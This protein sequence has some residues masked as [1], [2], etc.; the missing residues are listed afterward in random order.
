M[1][2]VPLGLQ[3]YERPSGFQPPTKLLNFYLEEDKSGA[4]PDQVMRLQRPGL[5]PFTTLT[6]NV[7]ALFYREG[8]NDGLPVAVAG[9]TLY[10]LD[11]GSNVIMG[12]VENDAARAHI[13]ANFEKIAV[14]SG[15]I[16]YT[17]DGSTLT[18]VDLP[19]DEA[20]IGLE[21]INGYFI[22]IL[23]DGTF[24]WLV[25][26]EDEIDALDFATAE[27]SPDGLVGIK[28]LGD[29]LFFFG[30][31][32]VEV[33]QTQGDA[34]APF[35]R[36]PGRL[37]D[38][39]C[40]SADTIETFDNSVVWVGE[41]GIV[42]KVGNVPTRISSE[43]IEELI[44]KRT[45]KLSAFT[46]SHDGHS[47]YVLKVPGQGSFAFD[48]AS[49][50]WSEF[51]TYQEA[52]WKP[53]VAASKGSTTYCGDAT[54]GKVWT[55]DPNRSNDDGTI[56]ERAV[57]GSVGFGGKPIR[58]NSFT[59]GVGCEA[60]LDLRVRWWDGREAI[61]ATW[62]ILPARAPVDLPTLWRLGIA[63]QPVRTFEINIIADAKVRLSGAAVND[64]WDGG[65]E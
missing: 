26:G 38:K 65:P 21:A 28:R 23:S 64:G 17:H 24:Y 56:M 48:A 7:R 51:G 27:S 1:P 39:G 14:V 32:T 50:V 55:L 35:A 4:S 3:S 12:T 43:G 29:E 49:K 40:I 58:C 13:A 57:S 25:P 8:I 42:Y 44:R 6:G 5:A 31:S 63:T 46:F 36:A 54:S 52:A 19:D 15:G 22:L 41:D 47:F 37:F 59:V 18:A 53:H 45:G 11:G 2:S 33:W 30:A 16:F 9:S 62:A 20:P 60:D 34:D 10:G 61:P